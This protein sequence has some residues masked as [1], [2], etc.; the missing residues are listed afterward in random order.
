M[1]EL[2]WLSGVFLVTLGHSATKPMINVE[3]FGNVVRFFNTATL[4][5]HKSVAKT[6]FD[7]EGRLYISFKT[8]I[9]PSESDGNDFLNTFSKNHKDD[10]SSLLKMTCV[11]ACGST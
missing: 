7:D 1:K 5:E 4:C 9:K 3:Q 8:N 2:I 10:E 6:R 11:S